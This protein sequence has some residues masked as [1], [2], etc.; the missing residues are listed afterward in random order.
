M[1]DK[2][3]NWRTWIVKADQYIRAASPEGR[4][5]KFNNA[6]RYNMLSMSFEGY[7][8][9]V[10]DFHKRLPENHTFTDLVTGLEAVAPVSET[11]KQRILQYEN[12]QSICSLEKY[13]TQDPKEE[14]LMDLEAAIREIGTLAHHVCME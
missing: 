12:I 3:D 8:M 7:V 11:L 2:V 4:K 1:A 14:E 10:M 13:H 9:A 6:I 5:S